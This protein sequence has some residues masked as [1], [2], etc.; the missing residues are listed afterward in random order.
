MKK[1]LPTLKT[2]KQAEKLLDQDLS[3]FLHKGNFQSVRFEF[4]PK[5][6]KVNLRVSAPLLKAIKRRAKRVSLPYQRYIR[7]LLERDL[8]QPEA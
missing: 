7:Q 5:T 8:A 6:A 1:K 3:G 2:D 4:M